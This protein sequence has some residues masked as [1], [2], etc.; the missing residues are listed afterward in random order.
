M[1]TSSYRVISDMINEEE[2]TYR[3]KHIENY[4][5]LGS[6][7]RNEAL[8]GLTRADMATPLLMQIRELTGYV[9]LSES[10][11]MLLRGALGQLTHD[12]YLGAMTIVNFLKNLK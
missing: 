5:N 12:D 7:E 9:E 4:N 8:Q 6:E 1:P 3:E 11:A 10:A 2:V